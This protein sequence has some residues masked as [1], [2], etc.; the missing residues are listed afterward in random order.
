MAYTRQPNVVIAGTALKQ[1]PP[2]TTTTPA[3]V[4]PVTLEAEIATTTS[5]GVVQVGS[6]LS[7]TPAGVLSAS[8]SATGLINVYLTSVNYTITS[9]D[10]Y[11]G[12]TTGGITIT[13]PS[14]TT[15]KVYVIKNQAASGNI[16]VTGT[17]GQ[18]LDTSV[19]KTL[20]GDASLI[21][22]FDGTRWNLV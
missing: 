10:Y 13:L 5:L 7:I 9:S 17:G 19:N 6:G 1:N 11:V 18:K 4:V 14:G 8:G 2:P 3:G 16:T 22:V 15:G 12:G 21:V 20:G